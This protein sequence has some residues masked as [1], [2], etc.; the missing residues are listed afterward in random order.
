MYKVNAPIT[1]VET[2]FIKS[3]VQEPIIND[4]IK[5][6]QIKGLYTINNNILT[7]NGN[8]LFFKSCLDQSHTKV[9]V[10]ICCT[11]KNKCY[12]LIEIKQKKLK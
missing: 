2:A 1:V 9:A 7:T 3:I 12:I 5:I 4:L 11:Y 10:V 8:K 6:S